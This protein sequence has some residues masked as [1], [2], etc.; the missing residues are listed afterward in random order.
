M[1][2]NVIGQWWRK[3]GCSVRNSLSTHGD[4][5]KDVVYK[6]TTLCIVIG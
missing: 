2:G 6:K 4:F 1:Y 5:L 3:L